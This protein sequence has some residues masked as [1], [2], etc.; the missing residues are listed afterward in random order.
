VDEHGGDRGYDEGRASVI[1]VVRNAPGLVPQYL[2]CLNACFT[3]WGGAETYRWAFERTVGAPPADLMVLSEDGQT[4]AGSA[5]TYRKIRTAGGAT[6]LVGIMTG[7]WTLPPARGRGCFTRIIEESLS[8][9][10]EHDGIA[11]LAFVTETNASYRRLAAAGSTLFPTR[12]VTARASDVPSTRP[13]VELFQPQPSDLGRWFSMCDASRRN[14]TRF[15]YNEAEWA[16]QFIDRPLRCSVA[17]VGSLGFCVIEER[18]DSVRLQAVCPTTG[19]DA[20]L[21]IGA[22]TRWAGAGGRPVSYF[23]SQ[24][25]SE[26]APEGIALTVLPGFLTALAADAGRLAA[27]MGGSPKLEALAPWSLFSGDRM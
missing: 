14:A 23:E 3:G 18:G 11:L 13:E 10:R 5:V 17:Q 24:P 22:V 7:S 16:S 8:F 2:E 15:C 1:E 19:P 27:V 4:L 20:A 21:L 9:V 12:Y 25:S 6:G 26:S